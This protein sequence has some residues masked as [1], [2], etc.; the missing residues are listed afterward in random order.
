MKN[1]QKQTPEDSQ[2]TTD[3]LIREVTSSNVDHTLSNNQAQVAEELGISDKLKIPTQ[4][5]S[6]QLY[7]NLDKTSLL[8]TLESMYKDQLL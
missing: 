8:W 2:K 5:Q 4:D 1:E 7:T 3:A 6:K